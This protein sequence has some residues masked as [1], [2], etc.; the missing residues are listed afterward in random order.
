MTTLA[1]SGNPLVRPSAEHHAPEWFE[2]QRALPDARFLPLHRLEAPV[3]DGATPHLAW[4]D[5]GVLEHA[6]DRA[7]VVLLGTLG[8]IPHLAVA[9]TEPPPTTPEGTEFRDARRLASILPDTE[10]GILAQARSMIDWHTRHR[11]CAV[12]GQPTLAIEGGARRRCTACDARHYPR[13]DPSVIV[14]V[15]FEGRALLARRASGTAGNRRSC[16]A[17]FVEP[18]E[19]IEEAVIREVREE[20]GADVEAVEYRASQP[21]PFPSTLMIGCRARA[22]SAEVRADGVEI[23][24]AEWF[25]RDE[26]AAA[27]EGRSATLEVPQA[28]AIA[29]HLMREWVEDRR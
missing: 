1:F 9:V 26:V 15:E 23:D 21:W 29:H 12:C 10:A 2:S 20:V 19:S 3:L 24:S 18:G 28:I 25:D 6:V 22:R 11:F 4:W 5:A 16:V 8:G 13:V 7:D 14:L 17:G 27:L